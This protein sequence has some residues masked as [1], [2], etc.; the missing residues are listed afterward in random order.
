MWRWD[1]DAPPR[2]GILRRNGDG[3]GLRWFT[4]P[5]TCQLHTFNA[6]EDDGRIVFASCSYGLSDVELAEALDDRARPPSRRA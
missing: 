6:L 4:G 1:P 2:I 3:S 5:K